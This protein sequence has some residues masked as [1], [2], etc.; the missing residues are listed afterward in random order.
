MPE[1]AASTIFGGK[2]VLGAQLENIFVKYVLTM[3][4]KCYGLA[5]DRCSQNGIYATRHS[6]QNPFHESGLAKK[7]WSSLF[8]E[9]HKDK[10]SIR[11]RET[12]FARAVGFN[13]ENVNNFL[14]LWYA[15]YV[16]D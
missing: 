12:S 1:E 9:C 11:E 14:Q 3:E 10:L 7:T 8:L 13:K 2:T 16:K 15:M 5:K 4:S 6:L